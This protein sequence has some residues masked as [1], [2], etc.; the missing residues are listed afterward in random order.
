MWQHFLL[1]NPWSPLALEMHVG[2]GLLCVWH[3]EARAGVEE[4]Q[5]PVLCRPSS[6]IPPSPQHACPFSAFSG[7][8]SILSYQNT[9]TFRSYSGGPKPV[10]STRICWEY[11]HG[12]ES[13][14]IKVGNIGQST[15][16]LSP[17]VAAAC[18][19]HS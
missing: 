12:L 9:C 16:N 6:R 4:A 5:G 13:L 7:A 10:I 11:I 8:P 15:W 14:H 18:E 17:Q 19:G 2:K 1:N 3:M